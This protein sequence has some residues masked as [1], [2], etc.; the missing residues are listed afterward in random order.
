[1]DAWP[2]RHDTSLGQR[3]DPIPIMDT[4]L[5]DIRY[6]ARKLL[7]APG[8]T[9]VA[10]TT[11]ALGVGATT[12]VFSIVSGVLLKPLP[13]A[14]PEQ[15]VFI[16]STKGE[17]QTNPMSALDFVDYR[18]QSKSFVGMA[19]YDRASMNATGGASGAVRLDAAQV[20]A[21]FFDL[22]AAKPH[23]GRAFVASEDKAGANR[24]V[25]LG[26]HFWR[27]HFGADSRVVGQAIRLDGDPYTV[28]GVAPSSLTFP[29]RVD[30]YVP[31]VFQPWM[32]DARNR[33]AHHLYAIGRVKNGITVASANVEVATIATR[34]AV[35]YPE[36]NTGFGGRVIPLHERIVGKVDKPLYAMLGA[37]GL[38]LLIACANVANLLLVRAYARESEMAVRTAL[39]AARRRI[40]RQ[41][42]TES[43]LLSAGGALLGVVLASWAVAAVVAFGPSGLPR[44]H[45]VV[46]DGRVLAFAAGVGVITGILFGLVPALHAA[47][48]DVAQMLRESVRGSSRGGSH[49]TR[50]AL[51]IAEMALAVVLLVGAG[52]L[53][54]SFV[55]LVNVD[56]GFN[57]ERVVA[58]NLSLPSTKYRYERHVRSFASDLTQRLHQTPGTHE[59]GITFGRPLSNSGFMRTTF[60]VAGWPRSTPDNR[61]VAQV[62][63]TS[64]GYFRAMGIPLRRGRLYTPAEDR[65]EAAP[66]I[67][68]SEAFARKYFA[69]EDPLGKHVT[70]GITHD[71]AE[72]GRGEDTVQGRIVGI[73]GDVKQQDLA[74]PSYPAVYAPFN[75]WPIGFFTVLVRTEADP[76]ALQRRIRSVV[77]EMDADLPIFDL[78]TMTEAVS[79]SVSQPRF[80]MVLLGAFAAI[81]LL[82]AALGIY[83][84]I[85]YAVSQ[86]TRELG[87]RVALGA[88]RQRIVRL[89]IAEGVWLA[90]IGVVLGIVASMALTR[91]IASLTFGVGK[92]DPVTLAAAPL[93]LMAAALLGCYLPARRA[94]RVDP[95]IAMRND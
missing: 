48:P 20:G 9:L 35:Q 36:S 3:V 12:A 63:M 69:A 44:L 70:L 6:A 29:A 89:V 21:S 42:V 93:T 38:V 83:G 50:S 77:R 57:P 34:L 68:V 72:A 37:V 11:L 71:T 16:S 47:R 65:P 79:A 31:L 26:H 76:R 5:Q 60:E 15:V 25:V 8:F 52:L 1:M 51:V 81:A 28:I 13:F 41:L 24:V 17:G 73:V 2:L 18:D 95:V 78:T 91:A 88:T 66:V 90:G 43:L 58:F 86:R 39:G 64:P 23:L 19:A 22:L 49:R 45:E 61:R 40:V 74:T 54:H 94:A 62:H 59:V 80:Y 85:A 33:G 14:K 75:T 46:I 56:P 30:V 82:L 84:V 4:L 87:I 55:R 27:D 7:R 10:V 32:L 53:I 92:L 67:V